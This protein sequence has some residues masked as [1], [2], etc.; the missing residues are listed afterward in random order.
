MKMKAKES[1]SSAA[2]YVPE[3]KGESTARLVALMSSRTPVSDPRYL[4]FFVVCIA[5]FSLTLRVY[6][7]I[8]L[9]DV[10][11]KQ[12]LGHYFKDEER[13]SRQRL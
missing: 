3:L 13:R 1:E 6:G 9:Q 5:F 7:Y 12:T 4:F 2:F 11:G 10:N 8:S